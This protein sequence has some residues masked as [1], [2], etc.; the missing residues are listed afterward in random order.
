MDS[1]DARPATERPPGRRVEVFL[2]FLG[3]GLTAFGGPVAHLGYFRRT[4]VER[5][6][7]L[8]EDAYADLVS[9][10]QFLPGPT[11]SQVGYALGSM[12][13]GAWGGLAAWLGFTLPSSLL[14]LAA[15]YAE[16][17]FGAGLTPAAVVHGLKL[18]AVAVVAQAVLSMARS[19]CP[20]WPRAAITV[21]GGWVVLLAPAGAGQIAAIV[22]GAAAGLT[23]RRRMAAV[24]GSEGRSGWAPSRAW[25]L[26]C[27]VLAAVLFLPG[28]L[29]LRQAPAFELFHAFY[30]SGALVFGGG[31]VV[32]PLLREQTVAAGWV[33]DDVF[34]AGYGAAQALPGP[35]FSFAAY[36]GAESKVVGGVSGAAVAL[37]AIFLPGLL[38]MSALAP[39][40]DRV[41]RIGPAQAAI[42]GVNAA[43]VGILAMALYD[44][45]GTEAITTAGD[46]VVALCA[47]ALLVIGRVPPLF[48]VLFCVGA[49]IAL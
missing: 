11:S 14:M 6:R 27:L 31:H 15:A 38:L 45:V 42:S 37:V 20:D 5:R 28:A 29:I 12:R 10:A 44:P 25:G 26:T 2:A 24:A 23:L 18:A 46:G 32:L 34:L 1:D 35:L 19:Q 21:L 33:A 4:F 39:Y 48:A 43:V 30:R 49:A 3:L 40:R 8:S 22:V 16:R 36:L 41:R 13:A 47:F 9:L 7:W 17:R